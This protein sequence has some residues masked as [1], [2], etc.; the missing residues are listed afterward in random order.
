MIIPPL[1][2][3]S[4]KCMS[5]TNTLDLSDL[6]SE[7]VESNVKVEITDAEPEVAEP[8][9]VPVQEPVPTEVV[10]EPV[11]ST[12]EVVEN[13]KEILNSD[14]TIC[15]NNC[16]CE[17]RVKVLEEKIELIIAHLQKFE[18]SYVTTRMTRTTKF[19]PKLELN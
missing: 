2:F 8:D 10:V 1:D 12:E 18:Q 9:P 5:D 3:V 6:S 19:I 13:V 14:N 4:P 16:N 15:C 11:V 17:E 7:P